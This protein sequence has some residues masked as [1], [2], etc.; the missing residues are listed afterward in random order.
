MPK[1]DPLRP[2]PEKMREG[3]LGVFDAVR[4]EEAGETDALGNFLDEQ[5]E[6]LKAERAGRAPTRCSNVGPARSIAEKRVGAVS[7]GEST[8]DD[9]FKELEPLAALIREAKRKFGD[10]IEVTAMDILA[11]DPKMSDEEFWR[12]LEEMTVPHIIPPKRFRERS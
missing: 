5:E 10:G 6:K 2:S 4:R 9:L 7:P 1:R 11:E 12:R 3:L 8:V